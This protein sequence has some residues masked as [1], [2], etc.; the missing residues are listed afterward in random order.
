MALESQWLCRREEAKHASL[1]LRESLPGERAEQQGRNRVERPR[2]AQ[3][4]AECIDIDCSSLGN[5]PCGAH[6][7]FGGIFRDVVANDGTR[8]KS[9]D[10]VRK[11]NE[12]NVLETALDLGPFL[13]STSAE[14]AAIL[15]ERLVEDAH[16]DKLALRSSG[17]FG[18]IL[19]KMDVAG[20][21]RRML[22]K[23]AELVDDN[24]QAA[25][26]LRVLLQRIDQKP[27]IS[28]NSGD[29]IS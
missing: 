5:R 7:Q 24:Q 28:R 27:V 3:D 6:R 9:C 19:Q 22:E 4:I 17:P 26:R 23:L 25:S 8:E 1:V 13:A 18:E 12:R 21:H 15:F 2:L 10:F 16:D 14:P 11:G 20:G 29:C